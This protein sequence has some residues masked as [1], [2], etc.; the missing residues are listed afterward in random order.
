MSVSYTSYVVIGVPITIFN[1][2][3][4]VRKYD[5]DTGEPVNRITH[6]RAYRFADGEEFDIT[7][8]ELEEY[9]EAYDVGDVGIIADQVF[10]C[11]ISKHDVACLNE[12]P[13]SLAIGDIGDVFTKEKA[14]FI[15]KVTGRHT[16]M[17]H[18]SE[19]Y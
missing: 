19:S 14:Q 9:A 12:I 15:T 6:Q 5:P 7:E 17:Y 4:T 16:H 18:A 8:D 10:G 11:I 1:K 3:I 13:T 2:E